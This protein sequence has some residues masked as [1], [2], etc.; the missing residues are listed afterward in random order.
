MCFYYIPGK[1]CFYYFLHVRVSQR[2]I[3]IS[4]SL[5]CFAT[6]LSVNIYH[7]YTKQRTCSAAEGLRASQKQKRGAQKLKTA[8]RSLKRKLE[9]S[10]G[11]DIPTPGATPIKR[12]RK[13]KDED[14]ERCVMHSAI[15]FVIYIAF[16]AD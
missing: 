4:M 5:Y 9:Q 16:K 8:T 13:E 3:T 15:P 2:A 7:T 1:V 14:L 6:S 11:V 10:F 12:Q